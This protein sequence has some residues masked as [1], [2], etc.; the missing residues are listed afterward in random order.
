[1]SQETFLVAYEG[2]DR[3]VVNFAASRAKKLGAKLHLVHV[4]EW[5][6]YA[7]LTPQ[8]L[9][10]RHKRRSEELKRAQ[11]VIMDPVLADLKTEGYEADGEIRYG[12]VVDL[13]AAIAK[14]VGA[15]MI[16][17]GRSGTGS[18]AERVFGSVPIGLAQTAPVPVVIVP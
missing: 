15:A 17:V 16:F 7:F 2:H 8:E 3:D 6:P 18:V 5:S 14:D 12:N 13:I 9:E 11:A 1:M 10:E 4:L